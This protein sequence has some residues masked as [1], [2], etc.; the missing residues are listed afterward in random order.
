MAARR[1]VI[2]PVTRIEGHLRI[3][4]SIDTAGNIVE[5]LSAGTQ[6]RGIEIILRGRDPRDAWAFAQRI[7]GVCT[8]VHG[9]ASVRAVED[10]L[11]ITVPEN[12]ELIRDLMAGAQLLQDHVIHFYHLQALDWV[13]P[14]HALAADP[15]AASRIAETI[16][17]SETSMDH[18]GRAQARLKD[19]VESGQLGIFTNGWWNHPGYKLAPEV[20]L[21][22]LSHY[23]DALAWQRE[24][25]EL[26][27]IF[28]GKNPH[29]NVAVGGAPCAISVDGKLP[30]GADATAVSTTGLIR[31]R[32]LIERMRDFVDG[33]YL[34]DLIA[35]GGGY[36]DWFGRG[37]NVRNFLTYGDFAGSAAG[38]G[39]G[40]PRGA[41]LGRD[42]SEILPVDLQ[43]PAQIQEYVAHSWY[44]YSRDTGLHPFEGETSLDYT[45][46]EPP[47]AQLDADK[48]YS[49]VK[50]PRWRGHAMETGPLARL[51]MLHAAGDTAAKALTAETLARLGLPFEAI[52]STFG[53]ILARGI[54]SKLLVDRMAGWHARLMANI[55]RGDLRTFNDAKWAPENWPR[56]SR[57]IGTIEGP[58][59]ALAHWVVID[60]GVITN[61]QAVVP[62]TW[63]AGPKDERGQHGPYEA[64]LMDGHR[65]EVPDKPLEVLRTIHSFD[66]CMACAAHVFD[67]DR[68]PVVEV[69]IR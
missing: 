51:V 42:L 53:R 7:C 46:P 55:G 38:N 50:A 23:L 25:G 14:I 18:F 37:E 35:I 69:K 67:I 33:V 43:D 34:P 27:T 68:R 2:D 17:Y 19:L 44:K 29:P 28:G 15:Q 26:L 9:L 10:A 49:W 1:I 24:I 21:I 39:F 13:N 5:A 58:R 64:A 36:K 8:L 48:T 32:A 22:A 4:V 16:G 66:P 63:N 65:L 11:G 62:T 20:D 40:V 6:V 12:G 56:H 47:F 52:Y 45:G 30:G 41:V 57:G 59:G 60:D 54:E 31:V 3:E 61:Y